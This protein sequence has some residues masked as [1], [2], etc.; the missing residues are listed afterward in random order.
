MLTILGAVLGALWHPI[1]TSS[2]IGDQSV[3]ACHLEVFRW[4]H[5]AEMKGGHEATDNW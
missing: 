3:I 5:N 2:V 4:E 1:L